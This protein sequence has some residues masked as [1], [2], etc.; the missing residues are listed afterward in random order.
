[1]ME[2]EEEHLEEVEADF[3]RRA[4]EAFKAFAAQP[5]SPSSVTDSK[6]QIQEEHDDDERGE[7]KKVKRP[8]GKGPVQSASDIE[9]GF[10]TS[11]LNPPEKKKKRKGSRWVKITF[12]FYALINFVSAIV[13]PAMIAIL[14]TGG[15]MSLNVPLVYGVVAG[16]FPPL[17]FV[18]WCLIYDNPKAGEAHPFA[19]KQLYVAKLLTFFNVFLVAAVLVGVLSAIISDPKSPGSI[20]LIAYSIS[21]FLAGLFHGSLGAVICG[22]VYLFLIPMM[23]QI[24]IIYSFFSFNDISWGTRG[25]DN[26]ELAKD[27]LE[28]FI[29]NILEQPLLRWIFSC[30]IKKPKPRDPDTVPFLERSEEEKKEGKKREEGK[31]KTEDQIQEK[32]L[33]RRE[34]LAKKLPEVRQRAEAPTH[35]WDDPLE[36]KCIKLIAEEVWIEYEAVNRERIKKKKEDYHVIVASPEEQAKML[37]GLTSIKNNVLWVVV[38]ANIAFFTVIVTMS[39]RSDFNVFHK[40]NAFSMALLVIF[41]FVQC[42]QTICMTLDGVKSCIRHISYL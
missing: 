37:E 7:E 23:Y 29:Q 21:F 18:I 10:S 33:Q 3:E 2:E 19:Q 17:F 6:L 39:L 38:A 11:N 20:F 22:V 12:I 16:V 25:G 40:V 27:P 24:L 8:E 13:S 4:D 41:G 34:E 42:V 28:E 14:I 1:M 36:M 30:W 32:E 26:K 5:I 9:I 35:F 31:K 15:I